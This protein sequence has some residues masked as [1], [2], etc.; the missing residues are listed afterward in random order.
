VGDETQFIIIRRKIL[1]TPTIAEMYLTAR[2]AGTS[3]TNNVDPSEKTVIG[4]QPLSESRRESQLIIHYTHEQRLQQYKRD[5]HQL[6]NRT[7]QGTSVTSTRLI[8]GNRNSPNIKRQIMH[9]RNQSR[10]KSEPVPPKT[11]V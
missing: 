8:I 11:H 3:G 9:T 5:I 4:N 6:W 2:V 1:N 10:A 7:F